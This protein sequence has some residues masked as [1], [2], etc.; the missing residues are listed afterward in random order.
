MFVKILVR[1]KKSLILVI[2]PLGQNIT[3]IQINKL[4]VGW[5]R[6]QVVFLLKNLLD[7]NSNMYS[8]V[9][10]DSSKHKECYF[11]EFSFFGYVHDKMMPR[12]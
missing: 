9:V 1:I 7:L 4:L 10:D 2:I 8:F 5:K 11:L 3:T 6:K 12:V